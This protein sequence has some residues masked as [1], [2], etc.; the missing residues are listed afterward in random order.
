VCLLSNSD[1]C[2]GGA[3]Q[4]ACPGKPVALL[5]TG[6]DLTVRRGSPVSNRARRL[7]AAYPTNALSDARLALAHMEGSSLSIRLN[8]MGRSRKKWKRKCSWR[9]RHTRLVEAKVPVSLERTSLTRDGGEFALRRDNVHILCHFSRN[10]GDRRRRALR[11]T[12]HACC[13][14]S[15]HWHGYKILT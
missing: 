8:G 14:R 2:D 13:P 15:M 12:V 5:L 7:V 10:V 1:S 9:G 4:R 6:E 11:G 3:T